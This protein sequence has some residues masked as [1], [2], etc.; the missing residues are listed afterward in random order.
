MKAAFFSFLLMMLFWSLFAEPMQP[1]DNLRAIE[2]PEG[3][4][5]TEHRIPPSYS[6]T[7]NPTAIITNYYDYMIGSYNGLPLQVI[8]QSA[9]GGYFMTYHGR[10][11]P[12]STRR[13]F[14]TYI[15]SQ[16]N[17][18]NNNEITS[19]INHEGYSTCAVDPV[20]GKPM[21][22]WHANKDADGELE[23]EYTSDAFIAGISGLF[24]NTQ[25]A[26]NNPITITSPSGI[27]T[28]TNEFIWP[29]AQIG[30]SPVAG[31]RRIYLAC[32]NSVYQTYGPSENLMIAYAD[33]NGDDIQ[34][35]VPL[36]WN[37]NTIPEMNQWN[38]DDE[39][40]RPFHAI[41]TDNAGNVYYA[42]YHFATESD[43]TTDINEADIDVF[44]CPNYG[45]G[46]WTRISSYSNLSTWNPPSVPGGTSGY[47]T[48][49]NGTPYPNNSL[50]WAITNSSHL[51]AVSDN[52]GNIHVP[53][54]WGLSTVDGTYYPALQYVKE[55]VFNPISNQFQI[56]EIFPQKNTSD[57]FN[58]WFTPWDTQPPWG[59]AEYVS[60]GAG[61][62]S[63]SIVTDWPFPHWDTS[64]HSDAM[65]FHYNN[66]KTS[67][68]NDQGMM[69]C[70]WQNSQRARWYNYNSNTNYASFANTP[71]IYISVSPDNGTNWSEPIILNNV[72]TPQLASIKPMWVYPA[73]KVI[74]T[75][76][77]GN[78]KV[79]KV[80]IMFYNDFTWG[81]NSITPSYHPTP[82]GGEVMF[83]ELQ[84]VFPD[85]GGPQ[86]V[87]TPT[88]IPPGGT[89]TQAQNVS[90]SCSTP[91][92]QI[93]YTMDGSE[94]TSASAL[95]TSP[96]YVGT[97]V[98]LKAKGY[99]TGWTPS[100][101]AVA[102]YNITMQTVATPTFSPPAGAYANPQSVTIACATAGATIYYT[103]NGAD[104]TESSQV[105]VTP[106]NVSDNL[107]L[108]ARAYKSNMNPSSVE[109][110]SY[111][112][113]Y[114]PISVQATETSGNVNVT[115]IAPQPGRRIDLGA[116]RQNSS[117]LKHNT[118][119]D[120]NTPPITTMDTDRSL[121]GYRV[122]RFLES[123]QGNES[124]WTLLTQNV[125]T[126]TS[127][128]DTGW[129]SVP[130]GTYKWA[131][132][133]VYTGNVLS[134]AT[135]SNAL[136]IVSPGTISGFVRNLDN[137]A[138]SGAT[139]TCDSE[140]VTSSSNGSYSMSVYPG[141]YNVT[142]S[143]P[144][145]QSFTQTGVAVVSG[146][147]TNLNFQL[148]Y[149]NN[150]TESFDGLPNFA[151]TFAPWTTIDVDQSYTLGFT[152]TTWNNMNSPQA[153][154][155]FNPYL[156]TPPLTDPAVVP[157]SGSRM[158][159]SFAAINPPNN[160]W[161]ISPRL[162][163]VNR[164]RFWAKSYSSQFGL[165]RFRVGVSTSD[166]N[167]S[168]FVF[169]SGNDPI[170]P[171]TTW[172]EYTYYISQTSPVYFG[173]QCMSS[174]TIL[175]MIDDV[176]IDY[177]T[178][179]VDPLVVPTHS[180]ITGNYP[181]PFR[182]STT[183]EYALDSSA[184]VRMD[185]FN[186]KGQL[187]RRLIDNCTKSPGTYS[188]VWDGKDD[189][190]NQLPSGIYYILLRTNQQRLSKKVMLN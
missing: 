130:S 99:L 165:E 158:A 179:N 20:S 137:Q 17:I 76:M 166:T 135:V 74:Y 75:G 30:P 181:N 19:V 108:K 131:V 64:A 188:T 121:T 123:N 16:G 160:D 8:P 147:T 86:T 48:N 71:E 41:T 117:S 57:T 56:K 39:W 68:A 29:T 120:L 134:V 136:S 35:G 143:H 1:M 187:V 54:I 161:L 79:G 45:Q 167:P 101:T 98:T 91:G 114:P 40:R 128:T 155:I 73:N 149:L 177:V 186:I 96:I 84:I 5:I 107:T 6:F 90:I 65:L 127:Y 100:A 142:A 97:S 183:I 77:Q 10:R 47:F 174:N 110:A 118:N 2:I 133:A 32:R 78:Q 53:A 162:N 60:D 190:R 189:Q 95:Y 106:V 38:V 178:A 42:G 82:D 49:S 125:I 27:T 112:M 52:S 139:V 113:A 15:N 51:N 132:K 37:Q 34:N 138:I 151:L 50:F 173:I 62:Y 7:R 59:T 180:G 31:K 116:D 126:T 81:S 11:Q 87:S 175:L 109:T 164:L 157:H 156:T 58:Q 36:V 61:G 182:T 25:I 104:P 153:Y 148:D 23:V 129:Q 145:H 14:Y 28:T 18:V 94:P 102:T 119:S 105:Y 66:I 80:G 44:V 170:E 46:T 154:I 115:W 152:G 172:T 22:A 33:F 24:N 43:G 69:V 176:N 163:G 92:A 184:E 9:G 159:A 140:S 88:F 169:I 124:L 4:P 150:L 12:T 122:W 3:V 111:E 13:A 146:Q 83:M 85:S 185:V 89:Y 103:T 72:E 141:I 67:Q 21:Y 171:P 93:R 144:N 26:I 55:F 63:P 168:S 70:V